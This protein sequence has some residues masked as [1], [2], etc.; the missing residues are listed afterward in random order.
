MA[1]ANRLPNTGQNADGS[2]TTGGTTN[3]VSEGE[4]SELQNGPVATAGR[5][6]TNS[7]TRALT[8]TLNGV[9]TDYVLTLPQNYNSGVPTPL[10]FGFHGRGQTH[11]QFQTQDASGIRTELGSQAIMVYVKSHQVGN[12]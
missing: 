10:I 8:V 11:V 7:P 3:T 2:E 4:A 9:N 6:N 5:G 1:P 12:G